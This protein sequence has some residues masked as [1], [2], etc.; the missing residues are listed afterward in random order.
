MELY[1][2]D[3]L[4]LIENGNMKFSKLII[5][6]LQDVLSPQSSYLSQSSLIRLPPPSSL[7]RSNFLSAQPLSQSSSSQSLS[8]TATPFNPELQIN[9]HNSPTAPPKSQTLTASLTFPQNFS[10]SLKTTSDHML[11]AKPTKLITSP[12]SESSLTDTPQSSQIQFQPPSNIPLPL[13]STVTSP[14]TPTFPSSST[15]TTHSLFS[16]PP[17]TSCHHLAPHPPSKV[18]PATPDSSLH[19]AQHVTEEVQVSPAIPHVANRLM[20]LNLLAKT[21]TKLPLLCILFLLFFIQLLMF[22]WSSVFS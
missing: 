12:T 20:H 21:T 6:T 11:S 13:L 4:H 1:Y 8:A 15:P 14:C 3:H 19:V 5:E 2:K 16:A 17:S 18:L 9:L 10:S 22:T 7:L